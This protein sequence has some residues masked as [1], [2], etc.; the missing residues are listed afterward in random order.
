M[1]DDSQISD[2]Q[3]NL[4]S[5]SEICAAQIVELTNLGLMT[6]EFTQKVL[7]FSKEELNSIIFPNVL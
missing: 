7:Y 2:Q 1:D 3:L 4:D 6:V 5:L